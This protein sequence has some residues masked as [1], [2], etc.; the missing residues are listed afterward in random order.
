MASKV[1]R[2]RGRPTKAT[3]KLIQAVLDDLARGLNREQACAVNGISH[4]QWEVW[5]RR[6]EFPGLRAKAVGTRIKSLVTRLEQEENPAVARSIQ[7]LLERTKS[8]ENLFAA[9][10]VTF[11]EQNNNFQFPDEKSRELS[12]RAQRLLE[13]SDVGGQTRPLPRSYD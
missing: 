8:Y 1:K 2:K 3:P 11:F 12:A 9:P 4:D 10:A 5:E 7:W 6:P 13:D